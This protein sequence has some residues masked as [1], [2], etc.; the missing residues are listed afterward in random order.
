[1]SVGQLAG[2]GSFAEVQRRKA[3]IAPLFAYLYAHY[4]VAGRVAYAASEREIEEHGG[5]YPV[6]AARLSLLKRGEL[7]IP[8]W[9]V[10]QCCAVIERS[11]EEVM[12]AEWVGRFGLDGLG[13][14]EDAPVG[15]P[16]F[17][18][19]LGKA[20]ESDTADTAD[21]AA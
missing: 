10:A 3:Y 1:M 7:T 9:F 6:T 15:I 14:K 20:P 4:Y 18:P 17:Y 2:A 8:P 5:E 16:R 19:K 21:T 12:G 13:G 11:V